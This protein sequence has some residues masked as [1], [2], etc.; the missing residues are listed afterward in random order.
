MTD[1]KAPELPGDTVEVLAFA[2]EEAWMSLNRA[3]DGTVYLVSWWYG[4]PTVL[5]AVK[6]DGSAFPSPPVLGGE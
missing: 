4:E 5:A 3:A 2:P 1:D 6:P